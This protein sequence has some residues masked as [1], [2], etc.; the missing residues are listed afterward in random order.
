MNKTIATL[1]NFTI[2]VI[3][4][5]I[6]MYLLEVPVVENLFQF[7]QHILGLIAIGI[8]GTFNYFKGKE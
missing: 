4:L 5:C 7:A 1:L 8:G 6:G 3:V 2:G